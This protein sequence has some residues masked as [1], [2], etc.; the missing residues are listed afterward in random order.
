MLS[1]GQYGVVKG[2]STA[3]QLMKVFEEWTDIL[4]RSKPD[5]RKAHR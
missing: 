4:D 1:D 5:V 2:R 3:L